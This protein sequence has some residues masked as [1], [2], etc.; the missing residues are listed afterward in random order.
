M[1]CNPGWSA[2][3]QSL[4]TLASASCVAGIIDIRHRAWLIF[5]FLVETGFHHLGQASLELLTSSDLPAF[6]SQSAGDYKCEPLH[7]AYKKILFRLVF[8]WKDNYIIFRKHQRQRFLL[9]SSYWHNC[10]EQA[11][12]RICISVLFQLTPWER[13]QRQTQSQFHWNLP[14]LLFV[15]VI[16]NSI[17]HV[18]GARHGWKGLHI[19]SINPH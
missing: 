2:V 9:I 17:K 14:G 8:C 6:T 3:A 10:R 13:W 18:P 1:L 7:L 19:L 4:L 5:V 12:D 15:I 16:A 11:G